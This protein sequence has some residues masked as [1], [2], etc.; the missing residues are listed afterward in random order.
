M[1]DNFSKQSALYSQFRPTYPDELFNFL[2]PLVKEKKTAWDCGTG[3]GQL[4][5][6][7]A[8]NFETVFATDIS[9]NQINNAIKKPNIE[10]RIEHA[11]Q[12]SFT[13]NQFDLITVAQAVHWFSFSRFY[14]EVKRTLKPGGIIAIIGYS[15]IQINP[16][17]DTIINHLYSEILNKYWDNERKYIDENYKTIPFPFKEID[18]PDIKMTFDWE[19]NQLTGYLNTWSAVQ[20]FVKQNGTNP[21]DMIYENLKK[22]WGNKEYQSISFP[23]LLRIGMN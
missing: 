22:A 15:N 23:V 19:L 14:A 9:N 12:S 4:A 7:L 10:Y 1:K 2:Y 3:N 13:N 11:E 8:E 17:C 6:K 5:N 20:H 16:S 18:T 21:V